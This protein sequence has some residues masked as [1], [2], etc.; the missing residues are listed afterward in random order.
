LTGQFATAITMVIGVLLL[1]E[2][3]LE[4]QLAIT[5]ENTK[6]KFGELIGKGEMIS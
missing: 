3:H 1:G 4:I 2:T 5:P 6:I